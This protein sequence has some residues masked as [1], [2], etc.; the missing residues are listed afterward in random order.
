[1]RSDRLRLGLRILF[2]AGVLAWLIG[3]TEWIPLV[4]K[5]GGAHW[6]FCLA[7]LALYCLAQCVSSYRWQLLARSL[8]FEKKLG[9]FI[10]LYFVGMFFN[11]FLPTSMG[12]DVARAWYLSRGT[13]RGWLAA[14]SVVSDRFAGLLAL[15]FVGCCATLVSLDVTPAWAAWSFWGVSGAAVL[16]LIAFPVLVRWSAKCRSLVEGWGQYQGRGRCWAAALLLSVVVQ[17][18]AITEVWLLG[19]ALDL[20]PSILVY[21][22]AVPLTTLLTML[23]ISVN[24]V[25]VREGSLVLLLAPAG[26]G[27][28]EALA[29]GLLW[30]AMNATAGMMGGAVYVLGRFHAK[31]SRDAHGSVCGH[32]DQGRTGQPS[33]AA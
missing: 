10:A 27:A 20:T 2:S 31:E 17:L 32:T 19:Q 16:G 1:M 14:L 26:A 23:P 9:R 6:L 4:E 28:A 13:G 11:L 18:A 29:L 15:L 5:L 7:S 12:G 8:G 24:G 3:R 33:A 22:V 21:A 25:G 30:F